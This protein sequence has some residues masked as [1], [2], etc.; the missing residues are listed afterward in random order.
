MSR[1]ETSRQ[2]EVEG[3]LLSKDE[4]LDLARRATELCAPYEAH[5]SVCSEH[6]ERT[7]FTGNEIQPDVVDKSETLYLRVLVDGREATISTPQPEVHELKELAAAAVQQARVQTA[8]SAGF[9]FPGPQQYPETQPVIPCTTLWTHEQRAE[10][11]R[12][13]IE[14]ALSGGLVADGEYYTA[15]RQVAMTNSAGLEVCGA[16]TDAGLR[17]R[18]QALSGA[19]G[20]GDGYSRDAKQINPLEIAEL[21]VS[22]A[23]LDGDP[24]S[25]EPGRYEVVLEHNAV[26]DLLSQLA[27]GFSA[28]A[29]RNGHS[30]VPSEPGRELTGPFVTISEDPVGADGLHSPFDSEGIPRRVV[31]LLTQGKIHEPVYDLRTAAESGRESTGHAVAPWDRELTQGPLPCSLFMEHGDAELESLIASVLRGLL[32]TRFRTVQV[33]DPARA[34]LGGVACEGT[35]LIE[36]GVIVRPVTDLRFEEDLLEAFRQIELV[37]RERKLV[38]QGRS[39]CTVVPALKLASFNITGSGA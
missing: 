36:N 21:A 34:R 31:P 13:V 35:F 23:M 18:A 6:L 3:Q 29:V 32:I 30:F 11:A 25:L 24:T 37:S 12:I 38:M 10:G 15:T 9:S 39:R 4:A 20:Y 8:T 1:S 28:E 17:A 2:Q 16:R 19:S 14:Q 33:L 7:P 26:A 5:A 22:K 27:V